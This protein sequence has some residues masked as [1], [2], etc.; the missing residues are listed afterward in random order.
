MAHR[1]CDVGTDDPV[2][3][4]QRLRRLNALVAVVHAAQA[5]AMV[6]LSNTRSLPVTAGFATGAPG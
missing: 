2:T 1:W 3:D 6:V 4:M 5:V